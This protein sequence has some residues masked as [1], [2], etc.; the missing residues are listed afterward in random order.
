MK[1]L[2]ST[3]LIIFLIIVSAGLYAGWLVH[4]KFS[5]SD[6][7]VDLNEYFDM[8]G[9]SDVALFM[10]GVMLEERGLMRGGEVYLPL[11]CVH[12]YFSDRFYW[13]KVDNA[14][15]YT[16][17]DHTD[18]V[19]PG[20]EAVHAKEGT[21][22]YGKAPLL[23]TEE[24]VWLSISFINEYC[25]I[26][27]EVYS[28][29][30]RVWIRTQW[31][32]KDVAKI[33]KDSAVRL[34]GGVKSPIL[35]E[36]EKGETVQVLSALENW[37][38]IRT[39]DCFT[40][41]IENK[42]LEDFSEVDESLLHVETSDEE[43]TSFA[44][45][46]RLC[47]PWHQ[48]FDKQGGAALRE[49]LSLARETASEAGIPLSGEGGLISAVSPTW[50]SVR[51]NEGNIASLADK[52]YVDEAH[53]AGMEVWALVDNNIN[54]LYDLD[55]EALLA[56]EVSRQNTAANLVNLCRENEIDG[57][58]VDFEQIPRE[59]GQITCSSSG[60]CMWPPDPMASCFPQTFPRPGSTASIMAGKSWGLCA[61]TLS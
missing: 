10:Q 16:K 53:G 46:G 42:F 44:R 56:S 3:L 55:T 43:Y 33:K 24:E 14:L 17:E 25:P 20:E 48:V 1:N 54:M 47:V 45:N 29:P 30:Y 11:S 18:Y 13:G 37:S 61:I 22:S 27:Y 41:Y 31:G 8:H 4:E 7:R 57:I 28:K 36:V 60:S 19:F 12:E 35:R 51:D 59:A 58:N 21:R 32:K 50:F 6:E 23:T 9:D 26:E 49:T 39:E 15:F 38:E 40:G 34:R 5:Y 2:I 52:S